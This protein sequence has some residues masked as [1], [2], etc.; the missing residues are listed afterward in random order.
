[1]KG[2]ILIAMINSYSSIGEIQSLVRSLE[3]KSRKMFDDI[4]DVKVYS[5][6]GNFS[7]DIS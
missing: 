3:P 4:Y 7:P 2:G 6:A 5:G 1:M